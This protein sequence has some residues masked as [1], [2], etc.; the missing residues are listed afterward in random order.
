VCERDASVA[1]RSAW[2]LG[3]ADGLREREERM[4]VR[5]S[6]LNPRVPYIY[7]KG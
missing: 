2:S 3:S 7:S 4:R 1:R 6:D 5:M